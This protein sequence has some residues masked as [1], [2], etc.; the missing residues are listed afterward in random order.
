MQGLGFR[1]TAFILIISK[2]WVE[3]EIILKEVKIIIT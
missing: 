2:F 3:F 1:E